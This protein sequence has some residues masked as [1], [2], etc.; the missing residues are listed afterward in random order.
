MR[1]PA[2]GS[3]MAVRRRPAAHIALTTLSAR[4]QLAQTLIRRGTPST[5]A[6]IVCRFGSNRRRVL[7][8]AWLTLLPDWADLPQM[9]HSLA[10]GDVSGMKCDAIRDKAL[11]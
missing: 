3:G 4:M 6:R 1:R 2:R 9:K 5:I 7:L 10:I 8:L 11:I